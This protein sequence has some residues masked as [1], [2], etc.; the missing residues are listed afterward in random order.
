MVNSTEVTNFI[1]KRVPKAHEVLTITR[2]NSAI[3]LGLSPWL[4]K[5]GEHTSAKGIIRDITK[6]PA[7]AELCLEGVEISKTGYYHD[8]GYFTASVVK[9]GCKTVIIGGA[10]LA[11][12]GNLGL[13]SRGSNLVCEVPSRF[14]IL[15]AM[16]R[17]AHNATDVNFISYV[18][19]NGKF[20]WL[21]E[22]AYES[23][24]KV[25][26]SDMLGI[27]I[28]H[29]GLRAVANKIN[30]RGHEKI[31]AALGVDSIVDKL[32]GSGK[33]WQH[34]SYYGEKITG[35]LKF[36]AW[37]ASALWDYSSKVG[38][39]ILVSYILMPTAR[40]IQDGVALLSHYSDDN[41]NTTKDDS[42]KPT[43]VPLPAEDTCPSTVAE[44]SL[45]AILREE[46]NVDISSASAPLPL[47]NESDQLQG[48]CIA[49]S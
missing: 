42:V 32:A 9:I 3:D 41:K 17:Q 29:I 12:I 27:V 2:I 48:V 1:W 38:Y 34:V 28:E 10:Y 11:G 20:S 37:G 39:E 40:C 46:Y 26:V 43:P 24:P 31:A 47:V 35:P 13:V 23:V 6:L 16:D 15:A 45:F 49:E 44:P 4:E 7:L 30:L 14:L 22:A 18:Y 5:L 33:F 19:Q 36:V 25:V 8:E 21:M